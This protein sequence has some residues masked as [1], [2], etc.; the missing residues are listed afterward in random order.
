MIVI[1]HASFDKHNPDAFLPF[2]SL[3]VC[4][5][6]ANTCALLTDIFI[7]NSTSK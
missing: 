1:S 4:V 6:S 3:S 7:F 2:Y 5:H